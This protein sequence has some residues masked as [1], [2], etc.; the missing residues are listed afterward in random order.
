MQSP[1]PALVPARRRF[2]ARSP[3]FELGGLDDEVEPSLGHVE[4]DQVAVVDERER[5]ADRRLW[6]DVQDDRRRTRYRS[7][8]R[9]R[10]AADR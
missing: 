6:R 7:S 3:R 10:S 4:A 1:K 8:V 2:P 9:R 5:A